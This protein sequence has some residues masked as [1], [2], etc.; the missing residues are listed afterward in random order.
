[1]EGKDYIHQL[2][3]R[4]PEAEIQ[5]ARSYLEFLCA[6]A[7][8]RAVLLA[9]YDDEPETPEERAAVAEAD[10]SLARGEEGMDYEDLRRELDL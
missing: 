4:L 3:D 8:S 6:D 9:P 2:V 10:E 5:S 7:V 1:M